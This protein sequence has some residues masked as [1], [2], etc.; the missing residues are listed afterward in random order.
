LTRPAS[1]QQRAVAPLARGAAPKFGRPAHLMP[2][3]FWSNLR[4]FLFERP[5]KIRGDYRSPLMPTEFGGG[6]RTNLKDFLSSGPVPQGSVNS[7]LT[8]AWGSSFGGFG[9]RLREFFSPTKVAPLPAGI[10]AVKVK[11]IWSKDENFGWSQIIAFG[12]HGLLL[13]ALL[14]VP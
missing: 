8:V 7:R 1:G 9:S 4:Q 14:V 2:D 6:I 3:N 10:K 11:D 12:V 5:I 13:F